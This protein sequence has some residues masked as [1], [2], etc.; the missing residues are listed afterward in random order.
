MIALEELEELVV[1]APRD[2]IEVGDL[3]RTVGGHRAL[4][5]GERRALSTLTLPHRPTRGGGAQ[6]ARREVRT[7]VGS[8]P[9]RIAA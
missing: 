5:L 8:C 2:S 4:L 6:N 1:V 9:S 7:I 3:D